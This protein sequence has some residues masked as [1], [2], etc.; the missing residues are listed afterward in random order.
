M[1]NSVKKIK[2]RL[3]EIKNAELEF[4]KEQI[5]KMAES[6]TESSKISKHIKDKDKDWGYAYGKTTGC[7]R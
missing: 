6:K 5:L 4:N 2:E 7:N 3:E 1:F